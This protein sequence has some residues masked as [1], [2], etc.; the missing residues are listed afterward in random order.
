M[1][2]RSPSIKYHNPK[3]IINRRITK[4][5]PAIPKVRFF[6]GAGE[7]LDEFEAN[8]C[9]TVEEIFERIKLVDETGKSVTPELEAKK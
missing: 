7:L 9:K 1:R 8:K 5:G 4:E 6:A 2:E 3:L